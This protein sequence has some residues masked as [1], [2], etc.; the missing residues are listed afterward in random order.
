MAGGYVGPGWLASILSLAIYP[1]DGKSHDYCLFIVDGPTGHSRI[2]SMTNNVITSSPDTYQE[3]V[4][5]LGDHQLLTFMWDN[6]ARLLRWL[7]LRW[8]GMKAR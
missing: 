2:G 8:P 5:G 3:H 6:P 1:S 4:T 7:G